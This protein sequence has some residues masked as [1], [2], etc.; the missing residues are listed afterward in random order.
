MQIHDPARRGFASDNYSG[1]HPEV[2][3]A[4]AA[5]NQ[6]HQSSYGNDAYTARL[7]QV[8]MAEQERMVGKPKGAVVRLRKLA[9]DDKALIVVHWALMRAERDAG[10]EAAADAQAK[11]LAAHPGR[12]F[13]EST[14]TD[15]LRFFNAAILVAVSQDQAK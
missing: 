12:A 14:S 9:G 4:I 1:V 3:D 10:N 15:V 13:A 8:V 2:L 5:A 11:W 7:Q 6:G